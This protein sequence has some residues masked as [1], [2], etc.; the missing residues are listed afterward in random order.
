MRRSFLLIIDN[1][2][3]PGIDYAIFFPSGNHGNIIM[4]TRNPQCRNYGTIGCEEDH[5]DLQDATSLLFQA[6]RIPESSREDRQEAAEKVV[7]ALGS[8]TLAII[9]AGASI[10]LGFCSL[11]RYPILFKEQEEQ[12]LK[13]CP[14]QDSSTYGSVYKTFE[15][16]AYHLESSPDQSA[17]DAL[18]LL[19]TL[20][21]IHFQE[22]P[23]SMF[24]RARK[25]A[26][27]IRKYIRKNGPLNEIY[28]L[29]DRQ[30]SRLPLLMM[31]ESDTATDPFPWHWREVLNLLESYSLI[32][33]SGI[34]ESRS[35]S[36][37]PLAHTWTRI[38]HGSASRKEGWRAAGSVIALS[39]RGDNY[40][41]SHE[42]LRSHVGAYLDHPIFEYLAEMT[43]LEICQTHYQMCRF[44]LHLHDVSKLRSLLQM[45]ETFQTWT[46]ACGE[47]GLQVK[48]LTA[49]CLIEEGQHEEA[50]EL[51]KRLVEADRS[52]NSYSKGLLGSAYMASRQYKKAVTLLEH[53]IKMQGKTDAPENETFLWSQHE[54]GRAY[55]ENKQFERAV[56]LLEHVVE[57]RKKTLVPPH[58]DR[59]TSQHMLGVACRDTEQFE[60]AVE[61][62]RLVLKIERTIL[63]VKDPRL[64][65]T[66]HELAVAYVGMGDGYYERAAE[67]LKQV[68]SIGERTSAPDDPRLLASEHYLATAYIGMGKGHYGKAAELLKHIV[69]M[70]EKMLAPDDSEPLKTQRLLK[71]ANGLIEAEKDAEKD[72]ESTSASRVAVRSS[73]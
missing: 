19:Q 61:I 6:A 20:G 10:K 29:S 39:I 3:N 57:V 32:K 70:D 43:E 46:G 9:Q 7:N 23:E 38:R 31:L 60:K 41:I 40:D 22:I 59:L 73:A 26:I 50:I 12:L 17:A 55:T 34:G 28:Q 8:H 65:S 27:A 11:D 48:I 30:I 25:D 15:I 69:K 62:L 33:I 16:S 72:A 18:S 37:H 54:L 1:A 71:K 36:M 2:D 14:R 52:D 45:L 47:S 56:T 5:L 63:D 49:H 13:Y 35:F 68:V 24:S 44:V 53:V 66:K 58:R 64:L 21:F 42:K 67:L 51:L 4:T